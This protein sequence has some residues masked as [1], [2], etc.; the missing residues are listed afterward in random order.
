MLGQSVME[1]VLLQECVSTE[2]EIGAKDT[3][4][5]PASSNLSTVTTDNHTHSDVY[6]PTQEILDVIVVEMGPPTEITPS[7]PNARS[8]SIPSPSPGTVTQPVSI[9]P[10]AYKTPPPSTSSR[11]NTP[12]TP[13]TPSPSKFRFVTPSSSTFRSVFDPRTPSDI[14]ITPNNIIDTLRQIGKTPLHS[15]DLD[16]VTLARKFDL[17]EDAII[18]AKHI[19]LR[20]ESKMSKSQLTVISRAALF[21]ACRQVGIAKTFK[22]FD[23]DLDWNKKALWHK[24]FKAIDALLKKDAQAMDSMTRDPANRNMSMRL[25]NATDETTC[26]AIPPASSIPTSVRVTDFI[27]SESKSLSLSSNIRSRAVAISQH[28]AIDSLFSGKRPSATAAV[29]LS[30]AAECEE[31]YLGSAPYAQAAN[32]STMTIVS[33]QKMLLRCVE[34][35]AGRGQLPKPFRA[36]WNTLRYTDETEGEEN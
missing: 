2:G 23:S 15:L 30:F 25:D 21:A 32:V 8:P 34:E 33:G 27:S 4:S 28:P 22:E 1:D 17:S 29:I 16:L 3:V 6:N 31:H 11:E 36:R 5:K 24:T 10:P 19:V 26:Q 35:M 14:R 12:P 13:V 18:A 9:P 20:Y 7:T